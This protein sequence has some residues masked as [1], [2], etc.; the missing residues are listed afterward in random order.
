MYSCLL[1]PTLLILTAAAEFGARLKLEDA[2]LKLSMATSHYNR[3]KGRWQKNR[4]FSI[5]PSPVSTQRCTP[6]APR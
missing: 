5:V 4:V 2:K 3:L 1:D 6:R